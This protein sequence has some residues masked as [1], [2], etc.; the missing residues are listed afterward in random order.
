ML[1]MIS[2]RKMLRLLLLLGFSC[3]GMEYKSQD[4][5]M[6]PGYRP[7]NVVIASTLERL[8]TKVVQIIINTVKSM[9]Q[10]DNTNVE[11]FFQRLSERLENMDYI[12]RL[13]PELIDALVSDDIFNKTI[14]NI[15]NIDTSAKNHIVALV[16][17]KL[18]A[19][20]ERKQILN[21]QRILKGEARNQQQQERLNAVP[22]NRYVS[23]STSSATSAV[24][25]SIVAVSQR[26][27]LRRTPSPYASARIEPSALSLSPVNNAQQSNFA[28]DSRYVSAS[29]SS[30]TSAVAQQLPSMSPSLADVIQREPSQRMSSPN[31][32]A[33]IEPSALS[34]SPVNARPLVI[35]R[36]SAFTRIAPPTP[37]PNVSPEVA[38]LPSPEPI[39]I[40]T[41]STVG[42]PVSMAPF[43]STPVPTMITPSVQ[44]V[45]VKPVL[46]SLKQVLSFAGK[47]V[48]CFDQAAKLRRGCYYWFHEELEV[49]LARFAR[50]G[51]FRGLSKQQLINVLVGPLSALDA[52]FESIKK[53]VITQLDQLFTP[54]FMKEY[55]VV[56]EEEKE[57]KEAAV[58]VVSVNNE[59]RTVQ[60]CA[61]SSSSS[62]TRYYYR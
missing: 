45:T 40:A 34:L 18:Q 32:P 35:S 49:E 27:T 44:T 13:T 14:L 56:P 62:T 20:W 16:R 42:S 9:Q 46:Y 11:T 8:N 55:A 57:S 48:A 22:S 61:C 33:R 47:I 15:V 59:V 54:S 26:E 2:Y 7:Q 39:A 5:S 36:G 29:T 21:Q 25:P 3:S 4:L 1:T 52:D 10:E 23:G 37:L 6:L 60:N 24:A 53:E 38:P 19:Q 28:P 41:N 51:L 17:S 50:S 58:P 30:A 43:V 31:T 12:W